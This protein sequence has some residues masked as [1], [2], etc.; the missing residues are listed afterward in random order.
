MERYSVLMSVYIKTDEQ[1]LAE[2][3]DSM[4]SQ[5]LPPEQFVLVCDG[6]VT[7]KVAE[8]IDTYQRGNPEL[9]T[10]LRFSEHRGLGP[11][12][13]AGLLACRNEWVARMDAD[14]IALPDRM[15][16]QLAAVEE[17]DDPA[18]VGGQI[19]EFAQDTAHII[20]YR[21]VPLSYEQ[22]RR[23]SGILCPMN[24]MTVLLRKSRILAVGGYRDCPAYEDYDLWI[25]L[26]V[27][28]YRV[29]NIPDLCC[30][31]R[32]D[33]DFYRRRGGWHYFQKT[34][35]MERTILQYRLIGWAQYVCNVA[36]RFV[37]TVLM[38]PALREWV[39]IH[40]LR[41]RTLQ[42][43]KTDSDTAL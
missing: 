32:V 42:A 43:L 3:T 36:I 18:A 9:F 27:G 8:R 39:F 1:Q 11:V 31:A 2:A 26:L 16:K 10:I 4:L 24:H 23:R 15:E 19:A 12:L 25:R 41:H 34:L 29:Y 33:G 20:G 28:D 22:I 13:Q 30:Y 17:L 40:I 38:P 35:H 37:C 6:P 7:Q 14:D 5:T 21:Q